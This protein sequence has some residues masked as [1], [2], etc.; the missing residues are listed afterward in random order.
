LLKSSLSSGLASLRKPVPATI[1]LNRPHMEGLEQL[2]SLASL[3][4]QE[5][6]FY[7][8]WL[9]LPV[10]LPLLCSQRSSHQRN[11]FAT[12]SPFLWPFILSIYKKSEFTF[13]SPPPF[14]KNTLQL[15]LLHK[16]SPNSLEQSE[17]IAP[18][19]PGFKTESRAE[20]S[21]H[22]TQLPWPLS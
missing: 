5:F 3:E 2:H 8:K 9:T 14:K 11:C 4:G 15:I 6:A 12:I 19:C 20:D 1:H 13:S 10:C 22:H 7:R 17:L 16:M 21:T 18:K